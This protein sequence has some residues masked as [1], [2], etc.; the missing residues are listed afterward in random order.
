MPLTKRVLDVGQ[1]KANHPQYTHRHA[2]SPVPEY[3]VG[4]DFKSGSVYKRERE[5][6]RQEKT[7]QTL[8]R[9]MH[10]DP[11]PVVYAASKARA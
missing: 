8:P 10:M 3:E 11:T 5:G 2:V 4:V 9:C 7:L 6:E 1:C